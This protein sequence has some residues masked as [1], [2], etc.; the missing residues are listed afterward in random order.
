[1]YSDH[2]QHPVDQLAEE[3]AQAIPPGE[4]PVIEASA[5][6]SRHR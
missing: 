3:F 6:L 2:E 5:D 4:T 1:M